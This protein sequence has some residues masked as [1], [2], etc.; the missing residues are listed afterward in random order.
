MLGGITVYV[1]KIEKI[2]IEEVHL[3]YHI[4][5]SVRFDDSLRDAVIMNTRGTREVAKLSKEMKH[6]EVFFHFSTTYCQSDKKVVE[7]KLYPP[8]ADW[9]KTIEVI[10]N[11]DP[12]VLE[13]LT[14]K[15]TEPLPNT[16]TFSKSLAEH[17]VNDL[18]DGQIPAIILRPSIVIS[19]MLEPV[20]GW[21]DNFNGPVGILVAS[22][23][24]IMRSVYAKPDVIA[25]YVPCDT[26]AQATVIATWK[27]G[28][29]K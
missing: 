5:A 28:T 13:V 19:T 23:K 18:C 11:A 16:Y 9:R 2:L 25:D 29:E 12:H 15:Y 6:L 20:T 21:I 26:V 17:V 22:G 24:G 1:P 10:E 14:S 3:V 4:A 8:H 27:K 7:E